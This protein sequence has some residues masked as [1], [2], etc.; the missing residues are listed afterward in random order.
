MPSGHVCYLMRSRLLSM[1]VCVKRARR[2]PSR[3]AATWTRAS[4]S[5]PRCRWAAW[6][7]PTKCGVPPKVGLGAA[8]G[9][10]GGTC[11][12]LAVLRTV[13]CHL[14]LSTLGCAP[15]QGLPSCPHARPQARQHRCTG[16][17]RRWPGRPRTALWRW[18]GWSW[19]RRRGC[20]RRTLRAAHT[21]A[22]RWW[23]PRSAGWTL[24]AAGR[25]PTAAGQAGRCG[26]SRADAT[27][28]N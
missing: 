23:W 14:P 5:G 15:P 10:P 17:R 18:P 11:S 2:P 25:T 22:T 24:M 3:R 20:S 16:C 13:L 6:G 28:L 19:S 8:P 12:A 9:R 4:G 21:P 26:A 1:C 7:R 27:T